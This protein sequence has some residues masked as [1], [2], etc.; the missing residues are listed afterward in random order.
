MVLGTLGASAYAVFSQTVGGALAAAAAVHLAVILSTSGPGAGIMIL[1]TGR[2][3]YFAG[4]LLI[5][6]LE[7]DSSYTATYFFLVD[8]LV[9]VSLL[10]RGRAARPERATSK[11]ILWSVSAFSLSVVVSWIL[12]G[13]SQEGLYW[14]G[15]Y[16]VF[17]IL[18]LGATLAF[19]QQEVFS[20]SRWIFWSVAILTTAYFYEALTD[21]LSW[22][23]GR[24][25][26]EIL[27]TPQIGSLF[28]A[29]VIP[30]GLFAVIFLGGDLFGPPAWGLFPVAQLV[31]WI[32]TA[33][34]A[35]MIV[36]TGQRTPIL[37]F[38]LSTAACFFLTPRVSLR[39]RL[40][41]VAG[42]CVLI[43]SVSLFSNSGRF[44]VLSDMAH[45]DAEAL[46]VDETASMR[47]TYY[48]I[49]LNTFLSEPVLGAGLGTF[50]GISSR[51]TAYPDR[52]PHN[53]FL[54]VAAGQGLVGFIPLATLVLG[55]VT[56][57]ATALR[58]SPDTLSKRSRLLTFLLATTF[59]ELA[60]AGMTGSVFADST[61]W[62]FLGM[63]WALRLPEGRTTN[64]TVESRTSLEA[65]PA[66]RPVGAGIPPR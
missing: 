46:S 16:V 66:L 37:A 1:T 31:R 63:I 9:I 45:G 52:I 53:A 50:F 13:Y 39:H 55:S 56:V 40:A 51:S 11:L 60:L 30:I 34:F 47:L 36:F 19:T 57:G 5:L 29:S 26:L 15:A 64:H 42:V 24:A 27:D 14:L 35:G 49:C 65:G 3:F 20:T 23:Y 44:Q 61:M 10:K 41:L 54:E 21:R 38:L 33:L 22:F 32:F 12:S 18:P 58:R 17:A 28:I 2:F 48:R 4:L 8:L 59:Y 6:H 25:S 62:C 43:A 7:G